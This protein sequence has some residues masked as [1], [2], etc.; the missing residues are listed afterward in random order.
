MYLVSIN[1]K[2][3]ALL[4]AVLLVLCILTVGGSIS[5]KA[6]DEYV[7][8]MDVV[9][10]I[11]GSGSMQGADPNKI[12][13]EAFKEFVDMCDETCRLGYVVYSHEIKGSSPLVELKKEADIKKLKNDVSKLSY[14]SNGDTDIAL[15]LTKAL[16]LQSST[17]G[18]NSGRKKLIVER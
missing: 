6:Y 3:M 13:V 8:N 5:V 15:G 9:L 7:L 4:S 11:D 16:E 12:T 10:V 2:I 18:S 1:R 17:T 14:D